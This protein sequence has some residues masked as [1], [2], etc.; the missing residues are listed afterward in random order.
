[1]SALFFILPFKAGADAVD[2]PLIEQYSVGGAVLSNVVSDTQNNL[3]F[4]A[5]DS[6]LYSYTFNGKFRWNVRLPY[7]FGFGL[8]VSE[9][10]IIYCSLRNGTLAAINSAGELLWTKSLK[11]NIAGNA[12]IGPN[13]TV[14]VGTTRGILYAISHTGRI[15]WQEKLH[16]PITGQVYI[17]GKNRLFATDAEG[18]LY[19]FTLWGNDIWQKE[20]GKQLN[21]LFIDKM[22]RIICGTPQT[23]S[24]FDINGNSIQS[25]SCSGIPTAGVENN[26][27]NIFISTNTGNIYRIGSDFEN[28]EKIYALNSSSA[29]IQ[30]GLALGGDN[31][32]Y[33][34]CRDN[35]IRSLGDDGTLL[36]TD[37]VLGMPVPPHINKKGILAVGSSNWRVCI[38]QAFPI[39]PGCWNQNGGGPLHQA[40]Y[41]LDE[42]YYTE[43]ENI[44]EN[45][46]K[47]FPDLK[48]IS[49]NAKNL[50]PENIEMLLDTIE[51]YHNNRYGRRAPSYVLEKNLRYIISIPQDSTAHI[52][53]SSRILSLQIKAAQLLG[54]YGGKKTAGLVAELYVSEKNT[55]LKAALAGAL[56]NLRIDPDGQISKILSDSL[57][58]NFFLYHEKHLSYILVQAIGSITRY[59]GTIRHPS[60]VENIVRIIGNTG[61]RIR[62]E[63]LQILEY[64]VTT[65][66]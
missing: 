66:I 41:K 49:E 55:Q 46:W 52:L 33:A 63:L 32:L 3:Y 50:K 18:T 20:T 43:A 56:R 10:D 24:A 48:I 8:T 6:K 9:E 64:P 25:F 1:M 26:K 57:R 35:F 11:G 65:G 17:Y 54:T 39:D 34:S 38:Y 2:A 7:N 15:R 58:K 28:I 31:I 40:F 47:R 12:S 59:H 29:P 42:P 51:Y 44:P 53:Q 30:N 61:N 14:Y 36:W 4:A 37:N 27:R 23:I 5:E 16:A 60:V 22:N 13:S 45:I 21:L 19:A 62:N